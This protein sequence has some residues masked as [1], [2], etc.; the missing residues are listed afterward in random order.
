MMLEVNQENSLN[1][2]AVRLIE[3]PPLYSDIPL[4]TPEDAIRVMGEWMKGLDREVVCV[5]NMQADLRPI[6]MNIVSMGVLDQS[7]VHPREIYKSA[8][9]SNAHSML[10]M[11][12]H[13]S[14]SLE[15]SVEDIRITDRMEQVGMIL[16][17][18]LTDHVIVGRGIEYYS[19][20]EKEILKMK[21]PVYAQ[22]L[23]AINLQ[24]DA[25]KKSGNVKYDPQKKM[26][27]LMASLE[28]GM[29]ELFSSEK[30]AQ[31]L[32]TMAKFHTY[33]L[34]NTI[35]ISMQRPEATL[36]TGYERWKSLGRQVKKGEKAI[37]IIAPAPVK[38]K[39]Q[40]KKLDEEN[41]PVLDENGDPEMEEV[42]VTVQ[43]YKVTNVFDIS[44][45]EGDPIETLDAAELTA[46]VENYAEFLQAVEKVAPVP[47]RFDELTG[48]TKGYFHTVKQEI[49]IQKGMAESQTL[50]TAIH[51]TAHSLLHNKEE[52]AKQEDLKNR[53]T[54]EVEAESVA[55]V[56]CSAFGLDTSEYSFPYIAGWSS[57]KEMTELK[58]SMDVIRKTSSNLIK[59][60]EKEVQQLL[61]EKEK[62]KFLDAH[63][64]D[65][66]SFY[67]ADDMDYPV[68]GDFWE[69]KTLEEAWEFYQNHLGDAVHGLR[70]IGF[71]LQ[72]G[73]DYIGMEPVIKDGM[74]QIE[75]I[76]HKPYYRNHPV[77]QKAISDLQD[78]MRMNQNRTKPDRALEKADT[79]IKPKGREQV[80]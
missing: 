73:S 70:G 27:D 14:G 7:M 17:I 37:R 62:Q 31:Y 74:V 23:D 9:L 63:A 30:Y 65:T 44:Q 53:Q 60:I 43:K 13:P 12:N 49:V 21:E 66:I 46:S 20:R 24:A 78:L 34:N 1:Q 39:R 3:E 19:F 71:Q 47:I 36:V 33:S 54:K 15:P 38:E 5:V 59:S 32:K 52:M 67:V 8:I 6:N 58:A 75:E 26:D 69:Y 2:V 55:F 16:G 22:D 72:D 45:T 29:K 79:Q 4:K 50:K 40:Q 11:H 25:P 76:N 80:L 51:E 64:N 57:G 18:P 61:T 10:M 35:L 68:S 77:V 28:D 42:E 41:K 56:V 48:Q